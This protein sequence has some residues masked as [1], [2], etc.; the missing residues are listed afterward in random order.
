MRVRRRR[1]RFT[2]WIAIAALLLA[3]LAPSL[4]FAFGPAQ[5]ASWFEVCTAQGRARPRCCTAAPSRVGLI[6]V[7]PRA[8]SAVP[9][10]GFEQTV[11]A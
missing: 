9:G 11:G 7:V 3:S 5:G 6:N 10:F 4:S 8:L 2:G 1:T